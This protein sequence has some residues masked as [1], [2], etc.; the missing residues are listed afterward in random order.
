MRS[1]IP[2]KIMGVKYELFYLQVL[3]ICWR[4]TSVLDS[5]RFFLNLGPLSGSW[6]NGGMV[7]RLVSLT[8]TEL[9]DEIRLVTSV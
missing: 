9:R 4:D 3:P 5:H 8:F 1:D 7:R 6:V 2:F